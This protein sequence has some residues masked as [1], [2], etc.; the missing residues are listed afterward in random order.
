MSDWRGKVTKQFC[1]QIYHNLRIGREV[2]EKLTKMSEI[3]YEVRESKQFGG[4]GLFVKQN[5]AQGEIIIREAPC[6]IGPKQTSSLLCVECLTLIFT[7]Q[8]CNCAKC[9]VPLCSKCSQLEH[10]SMHEEECQLFQQKGKF[11]E[12]TSI[13]NARNLYCFLTQLRLVLKSRSGQLR[14]EEFCSNLE[15][16]KQTLLHVFNEVEN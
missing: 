8:P 6:V 15:A 5:I 9:G 14:M 12:I 16:R 7:S 11:Y 10:L 3:K 1:F 2:V 13:E 4:K